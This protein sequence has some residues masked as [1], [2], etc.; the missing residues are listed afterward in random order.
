[1]T[2]LS[3]TTRAWHLQMKPIKKKIG[4]L[5][6]TEDLNGMNYGGF[7]VECSIQACS[8]SVAYQL[9]SQTPQFM[10][11]SYIDS[12]SSPESPQLKF[13]SVEIDTWI[14]YTREM[15]QK[16]YDYFEVRRRHDKVG[17]LTKLAKGGITDVANAM[18]WNI[19]KWHPTAWNSPNAWWR[20]DSGQHH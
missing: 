18:G 13:R 11:G 20:D 6:E 3:H 19:G 15:I 12:A 4:I 16:A 8:L 10:V 14:A 1:M 9:A 17:K 5:E 7:R 2:S